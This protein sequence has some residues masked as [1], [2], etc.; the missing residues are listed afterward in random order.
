MCYQGR[1]IGDIGKLNI[2]GFVNADW[3]GDL[4]RHRLT[5]GYVF[6]M[7]SGAISCMSKRHVIISFSKT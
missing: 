6:K 2:H 5:S 1:T 4:D 7:F 3:V